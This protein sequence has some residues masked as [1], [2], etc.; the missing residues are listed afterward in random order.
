MFSHASLSSKSQP[1][2]VNPL[3]WNSLHETNTLAYLV[4]S[5]VKEKKIINLDTRIKNPAAVNEEFWA[6]HFLYLVQMVSTL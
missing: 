4:S 2:W 3:G 1:L 6:R 5:T